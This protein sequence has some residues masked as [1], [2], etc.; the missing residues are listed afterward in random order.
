M[1]SAQL[2]YTWVSRSVPAIL[3]FY[4]LDMHK[5]NKSCYIQG[6]DKQILEFLGRN[7]VC[8]L[9]VLLSDA[10]SHS[11][12]LHYSQESDPFALYFS[13]DRESRKF[14]PLSKVPVVQASVVVG[15]SEEEWITL[16][17]SGD[18]AVIADPAQIEVAKNVHYTKNPG[19]KKFEGIP[20]TVFLKFTPTWWRYTDFN[21]NPVT[22][23][24][25]K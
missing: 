25:N 23:I 20:T 1:F 18:L 17:M 10:S 14:E 5:S 8:V 16:Q 3:G 2:W 19:S 11:A 9:S 4:S 22:H 21:T 15:W 12:A 24:E 13:T 7:R 6:V